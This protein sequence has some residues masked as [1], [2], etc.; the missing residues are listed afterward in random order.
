[1]HPKATYEM[2]AAAA[3]EILG[4]G[5]YPSGRQTQLHL[6]HGSMTTVQKHFKVWKTQHHKNISSST[7][8]PSAIQT[9][10]MDEIDRQVAVAKTSLDKEIVDAQES[11]DQFIVE[12]EVMIT[13]NEELTIKTKKLNDDL[14]KQSEQNMQLTAQ[15]LVMEETVKREHEAAEAA[16]IKAAEANLQ[17]ASLPGLNVDLE[18][19][20]EEI[21]TVRNELG[22]AITSAAV[23]KTARKGVEDAL[24]ET[25]EREKYLKSVELRERELLDELA[26]AKVTIAVLQARAEMRSISLDCQG[27]DSAIA[28][29]EKLLE[30]AKGDIV[31]QNPVLEGSTS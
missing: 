28:I 17:I 23:E 16:R 26:Q 2:V 14:E 22:I 3:D 21:K 8:L 4:T 29:A 10:L 24:A 15:I 1:M 12:S 9:V 25:R 18:N 19:L 7:A 30:S 20:R 11:I 13:E 27:E 5:V 31:T 6:G